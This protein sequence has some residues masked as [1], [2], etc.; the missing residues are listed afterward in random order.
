MLLMLILEILH[1]FNN[2][3]FGCQQSHVGSQ[4]LE[5]I[6]MSY[7]LK[8]G[9]MYCFI[10]EKNTVR[11]TQDVKFATIFSDRDKANIWKSKATKK[12]KGF[13]IVDLNNLDEQDEQKESGKIKR[14]FFTSGERLLVYNKSKGRCAICGN[15]VPFDNFTVDHIIPLAKGGTNEIANLQCACDM[16]N[17]IKQDILPED[18]MN[19]LVQI[20]LYQMRI[21]FDYS[22]W[23][24]INVL[25]RREKKKNIQRFIRKYVER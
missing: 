9:Y 12:L 2:F 22:I 8:N 10:D 19:K 16:C 14:R 5:V 3:N 23:K 1:N 18:L 13:K 21:S 6:E 11:K 15:F 4:L 24:K 20:I 7:V 17:R 25:K